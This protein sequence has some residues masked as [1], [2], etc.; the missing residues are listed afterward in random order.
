MINTSTVTWFAMSTLPLWRPSLL[1]AFDREEQLPLVMQVSTKGSRGYVVSAA[2]KTMSTVNC[3]GW[4]EM[5]TF[6]CGVLERFSDDRENAMNTVRVLEHAFMEYRR[7]CY[8]DADLHPTQHRE[9]SQAFFSGVMWLSTEEC[10]DRADV[11][12]AVA[13]LTAV[14]WPREVKER[15][16]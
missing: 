13:Q 4:A 11:I 14:G 15:E 3:L 16:Y 6:A 1:V 7:H 5:P 9:V 8:G 12:S 10:F 2:G